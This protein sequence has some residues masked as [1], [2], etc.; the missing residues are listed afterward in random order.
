MWTKVK[1]PTKII[2]K[3]DKKEFTLKAG[4]TYNPLTYDITAPK[5]P[6]VP[7]PEVPTPPVTADATQAPMPPVF[8]PSEIDTTGL[9]QQ[10][11]QQRKELEES[12]QRELERTQKQLE[13]ARGKEEEWRSKQED[14]LEK[15]EPLTTPFRAD[16]EK[17][18]RERLKV[19][20]N[21]F[22]NQALVNELDSLLTESTELTRKL[23]SQKVP[24]LAGIQ[25]SERMVKA[26]EGV[27]ARVAVINAVMAARN[28]QIGTALT[29]IDRTVNTITQDRQ[30]RLDYLN[31]LFNWYETQRTEEGAKIF[32]LTKDEKETINSQISLLEND[33]ARTQETSDRVKELMLENPQLAA[34][35]GISLDDTV[36]EITTKLATA[37]YSREVIDL[38]NKQEEDGYSQISEGE[39]SS[40]PAGEVRTITDSKGKARYYWKPEEV[41]YLSVSEAEKLGVPYGTT[42][43]QARA[44]GITTGGDGGDGGAVFVTDTGEQFDLSTTEGIR[45]LADI[46]YSY[47]DIYSLLD[48]NTKLTTGAIKGLL[49]GAGLR[50]SGDKENALSD[51]GAT[52]DDYKDLWKEKGDS[53]EYGTREQFRNTIAGKF[54]ELTSEEIMDEI[55]KQ[56][57]DEWL[58]SNKTWWGKK[59]GRG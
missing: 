17:S 48:I 29:F 11:D 53:N 27:Q 30:D 16:I 21:Y 34:D 51:L 10:L 50:S 47:E 6:V 12:Y 40:K 49:E 23:Q 15:A 56:V 41:E 55:Y 33:L 46:G 18:E 1:K 52:I 43:T 45:G 58:K 20:E 38:R 39:A 54:S 31:G 32:N 35:S 28:N 37:E 3:S 2:R 36:E 4:E 42:K 59:P 25:Q 19:E 8:E 44:M 24:G 26:K 13:E 22:Q 7:T 57:S 5:T 9:Q 14:V